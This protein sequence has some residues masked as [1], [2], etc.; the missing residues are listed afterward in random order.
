[1]SRW[2]QPAGDDVLA[3]LRVAI[4]RVQRQA[5]EPLRPFEYSEGLQQ[6]AE[7]FAAHHGLTPPPRPARR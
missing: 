2:E 1:M 5:R 3:D 7:A 6:L 4:E